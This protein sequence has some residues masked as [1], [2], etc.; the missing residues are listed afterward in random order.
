[1]EINLVNLV[2]NKIYKNPI[3]KE[4][5]AQTAP[6]KSDFS[7]AQNIM[8]NYSK[9]MISFGKKIN[10]NELKEYIESHPDEMQAQIAEHFGVNQC[11][12]S[13]TIKQYGI[14]YTKKYTPPSISKE[15]LE[16]YIAQNPNANLAQIAEHFGIED[17]TVSKIIR[18]HKI[19]YSK[20]YPAPSIAK[21]ELESYIK[22]NPKATIREIAGHFNL[23][24][25][26]IYR[27]INIYGIEYENKK[28]YGISKEELES[29]IKA[30]PDAM[31][32]E[33]AQ[34]F[35]VT[36]MTIS[37]TIKHYEIEYTRK[38]PRARKNVEN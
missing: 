13:N 27:L 17:A 36:P 15:E 21:E 29:Y 38:K 20:K 22:A 1:M 11:V 12:I 16:N 2:Q 33:I 26:T 35:N 14:N 9:A 37:N 30:N 34:H 24:A 28:Q 5:S 19:D 10:I 6:S 31:L 8:S 32:K 18:H 7:L 23:S 3:N 25:S 4:K